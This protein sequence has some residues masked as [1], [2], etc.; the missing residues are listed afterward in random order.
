MTDD[1]R[2][3]EHVIQN[4]IR[5]ALVDECHLF[6]ANVGVGWQG[7]GR[8][9][10]PPHPCT[11]AMRPGDV[12]LYQARPF[13]TGLPPGFADTFGWVPVT[14][15]PDMVGKTFAMFIGLEIK[16]QT[17]AVR[18]N[19][20]AFV[21]AVNRAGGRAGFARS[22]EDARDIIRGND[23]C[24]SLSAGAAPH[25]AAG[26]GQSRQRTA[27]TAPAGAPRRRSSDYR[28]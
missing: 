7:T 22:V 23:A 12:L 1:R 21:N 11:V 2:Q 3:L 15:T 16:T 5:N 28:R 4:Q 14:I 18:D 20:I 27:R 25:R 10:K 9:F 26:E 13:D 24:I 8:P 6:R 17:G 19:Q